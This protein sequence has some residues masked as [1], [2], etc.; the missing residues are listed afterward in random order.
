MYETSYTTLIITT[1]QTLTLLLIQFDMRGSL[2][3]SMAVMCKA[4]TCWL[5]ISDGVCEVS[6]RTWLLSMK[7]L[8]GNRRWNMSCKGNDL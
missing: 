7:A 4:R 1:S 2:C 6:S 5:N 3:W 8:Y